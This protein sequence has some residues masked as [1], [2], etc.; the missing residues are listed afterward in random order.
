MSDVEDDK[1]PDT[2]ERDD[3]L[4]K[5]KWTKW[6]AQLSS[7]R[8]VGA[9]NAAAIVLEEYVMIKQRYP[10]GA[11][12]GLLPGGVLVAPELWPLLYF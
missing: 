2:T 10:A 6:L 7:K 12:H 9:S 11:E 1:A 8:S 5:A 3:T 4:R